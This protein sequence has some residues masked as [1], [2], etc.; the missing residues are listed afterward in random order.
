MDLM[1]RIEYG[2]RFV[3]PVIKEYSDEYFDWF[4]R[5]FSGDY[6]HGNF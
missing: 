5:E 3:Q 2:N 6:K 1:R 4:N